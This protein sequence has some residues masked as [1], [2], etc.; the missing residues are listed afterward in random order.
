[1]RRS[2]VFLVLACVLAQA[3]GGGAGSARRGEVGSAQAAQPT[4]GGS[5]QNAPSTAGGEDA[6][7]LDDFAMQVAANVAQ[8]ECAPTG[9]LGECYVSP[10]EVCATA[11]MTAMRECTNNLRGQLPAIVD[12]GNV[13]ATS[14][15]LGTC[16]VEAYHLGLT[17]A[18]L[19]S[20]APECRGD[21]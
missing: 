9:S 15:A 21:S 6:L 13:D 3:C 7:P 14:Q 20:T 11:F 5:T 12:M 8:A 10:P 4:R 19:R 16:A 17:Q 2:F 1:M 18:G